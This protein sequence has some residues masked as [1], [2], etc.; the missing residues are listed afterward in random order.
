[1]KNPRGQLIHI[2]ARNWQYA[3][4][5]YN[6]GEFFDITIVA[7]H[8]PRLDAAAQH[9]A[10]QVV[11]QGVLGERTVL[12]KIGRAE[13][14]TSATADMKDNLNSISVLHDHLSSLTPG[15]GPE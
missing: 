15:E 2:D 10:A 9:Y 12:Q 6:D 11:L 1:M 14:T 7:S 13:L 3:L 5:G 8:L 4:V